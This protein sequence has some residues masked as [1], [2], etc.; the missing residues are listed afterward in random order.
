MLAIQIAAGIVLA[1]LVLRFWKQSLWITLTFVVL[2]ILVVGGLLI[3]AHA[4]E[5]AS[6][7]LYV[8]AVAIPFAAVFFGVAWAGRRLRARAIRRPD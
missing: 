1:A 8:T 2:C 7:A 4:Q 3:A 5:I 6:S